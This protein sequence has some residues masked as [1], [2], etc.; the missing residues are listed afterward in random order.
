[1]KKPS[2]F[3]LFLALSLIELQAQWT[4]N[5][6]LN[7]LITDTNGRMGNTMIA[8]DEGTGA[9]YISWD[10]YFQQNYQFR[11]MLTRI[12]KEGVKVWGNDYLVVNSYPTDISD[13]YYG[14]IS[15]DDS[16]AVLVNR[17]RRTGYSNAWAWRISPNGA[18]LW[19]EDGLP[20]TQNADPE[21][22]ISCM[23]VVQLKDGHYIFGWTIEELIQ[24]SVMGDHMKSTIFLQ[25]VSKDMTV[26][27]NQ[28]VVLENDSIS[29]FLLNYKINPTRD[30]G[31]ILLFEGATRVPVQGGT[32]L[33]QY[34]NLYLQHFDSDGNYLWPNTLTLDKNEFLPV[35]P[36][37]ARTL[38]DE[39]DHTTVIWASAFGAFPKNKIQKIDPNGN[40]LFGEHGR[41]FIIDDY[42]HDSPE[43]AINPLDQSTTVYWSEYDPAGSARFRVM[44]QRFSIT[45]EPL[46]GDQGKTL[47]PFVQ[48]TM[49][50]VSGAASLPDGSSIVPFIK[51]K[52]G[53]VP[54][55]FLFAMRVNSTGSFVWDP[56]FT[57]ISDTLSG[58]YDIT[59][60]S[61][62][63]GEA[64]LVWSD[65]R[66]DTSIG[67]DQS[68]DI[69]AQNILETG[70]VGPLSIPEPAPSPGN[71]FFL[72]PNPATS[73]SFVMGCFPDGSDA[74][75]SVYNALGRLVFLSPDVIRG[76]RGTCSVLIE[77]T[78]L[79][80]GLYTIMAASAG[81][82]AVGRLIIR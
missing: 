54:K 47:I 34:S 17:D 53:P 5:T 19:G 4:A 28:P 3:T 2:V 52:S 41:Y 80:P 12:N 74:R 76:S 26:L 67:L 60:S 73:G 72:Y 51:G 68:S 9:G 11:F 59:M 25:K 70:K 58:K 36:I 63:N 27:W 64:V 56:P 45:G 30:G 24:D 79:S 15:D 50:S 32:F 62:T 35:G 37:H 20:M 18:F 75:I 10:G 65:A 81:Q 8:L 48:D 38:M 22:D 39:N 78:G 61:F 23:N 42:P 66:K 29:Y 14:L 49:F 77:T 69:V 7:T 6:R 16:C 46:W 55:T 82:T 44:A 13:T 43:G 31:F 21:V 1:M 40:I 71:L 33:K 57:A